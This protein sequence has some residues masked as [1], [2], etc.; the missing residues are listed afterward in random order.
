ML[1][2][3]GSFG[4][5]ELFEL[6]EFAQRLRLFADALESQAE[7]VVRLAARGV[8]RNCL[9][10]CGHGFLERTAREMQIAEL[11]IR[12]VKFGIDGRRLLQQRFNMRQRI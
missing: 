10:V 11:H 12:R 1:L 8:C 4:L 2:N 7:P 3:C 9:L 5:V 6:F